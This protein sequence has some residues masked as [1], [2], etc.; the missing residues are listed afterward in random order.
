MLIIL[1]KRIWG[2]WENIFGSCYCGDASGQCSAVAVALFSRH[3]TTWDLNVLTVRRLRDLNA[4]LHA[5]STWL[6]L[7]SRVRTTHGRLQLR[8]VV[9]L[10]RRSAVWSPYSAWLGQMLIPKLP[11]TA[12]H[13]VFMNGEREH[14]TKMQCMNV[15]VCVCVSMGEWQ[16]CTVKHFKWSR[17]EKF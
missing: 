13:L 7:K 6:T 1:F 10:T 4:S 3:H 12:V 17:Q 8:R 9:P 11:L 5:L 16:N 2:N 14:C 15:C